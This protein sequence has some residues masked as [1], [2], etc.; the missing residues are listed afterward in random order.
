M[1][2]IFSFSKSN[3]WQNVFFFFFYISPERSTVATAVMTPGI[4]DQTQWGSINKLPA[5]SSASA[6]VQHGT[7][8]TG[9]REHQPR[10]KKTIHCSCIHP[11]LTGFLPQL[12]RVRQ[13]LWLTLLKALIASVWQSTCLWHLRR[14]HFTPSWQPHL[15]F[16]VHKWHAISYTGTE[17][18]QQT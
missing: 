17:H 9:W 8:S 2:I 18:W 5:R 14:A 13:V 3:V 15:S 16:I 12:C 7:E 11:V 10:I 6:E 1:F 4:T